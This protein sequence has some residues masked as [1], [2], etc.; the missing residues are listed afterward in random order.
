[1][2]TEAYYKYLHKEALFKPQVDISKYKKMNCLGLLL[3]K[4]RNRFLQ[5][6]RDYIME[7]I[8][9]KLILLEDTKV[10]G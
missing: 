8:I 9:M 7:W 1:M 4:K 3:L 6:W 2:K 10:Y 5:Y